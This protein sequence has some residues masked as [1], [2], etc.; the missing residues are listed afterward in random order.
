MGPSVDPS[1]EVDLSVRF[2]VS[3]I[4]SIY[5]VI[6]GEAYTAVNYAE[7]ADFMGSTIT[8]AKSLPN[9]E[10]RLEVTYTSGG[11]VKTIYMAPEIAGGSAKD[12]SGFIAYIR[13]RAGGEDALVAVEVGAVLYSVIWS[14]KGYE[15]LPWQWEY[16]PKEYRDADHR[17]ISLRR[18]PSDGPP[19]SSPRRAYEVS[20]PPN[21]R[22]PL[23]RKRLFRD[24]DF[25]PDQ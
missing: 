1:T 7:G 24:P 13:C 19:D 16:F 22:V 20:A 21:A 14:Q 12:R 2:P 18:R 25:P 17:M 23:C 6:G 8:L 5:E 10:T 4:V 9:R 11:T 15:E 3:S